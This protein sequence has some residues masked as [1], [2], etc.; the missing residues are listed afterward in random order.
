[1]W[2]TSLGSVTTSAILEKLNMTSEMGLLPFAR[3][4]LI[5]LNRLPSVTRPTNFL[6]FES[7][8]GSWSKPFSRIVSMASAQGES[9]STVVT[10]F[11]RNVL[12]VAPLKESFDAP[13]A[14]EI[15][16][17]GL[18]VG[19]VGGRRSLAASQSSSTN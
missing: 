12:I 11:N 18:V 9:A 10:G 19:G 17:G 6:P 5:Q 3:P 16:D 13:R 2:P 14:F 15:G 1:M 7:R 4:W 8:T